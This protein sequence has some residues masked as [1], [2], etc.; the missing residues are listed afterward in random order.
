MRRILGILTAVAIAA[1][2]SASAA[3]SRPSPTCDRA[4][5]YGVL[6]QYLA[7]LRAHD[8]TRVP[9][10][11]R[12]RNTENN[13]ELTPGD[14]LWG[15]LTQLDATYEMRFAD[16]AAGQVAVYGVVDESGTRAPY[17]L[18]LKVVDRTVTEAE[19][20]I[21]RPQEAG[22]PF[23]NADIK[24]IPVWNEMLTPAQRVPRQQMIDAANGY[25]DSL[26]LNDGHVHT[27]FTDDCNRRE[28]GTQTTN[29]TGPG[30]NPIWKY[31]CEQQ[32]RL[33]AYR[34]DDRLR[35]RRFEMVDEERGIVLAGGFIDHS[36]R[37]KE[38]ALTDGTTRKSNY[39]RPHSFALFEAFKIVG[40][41]IRQVEAVFFSV[42]YNMPSPWDRARLNSSG[43]SP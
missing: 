14:G 4:C 9:W 34:Y 37:I 42:P 1:C 18:R 13:V 26:Q 5:L 40:G 22:V 24:S 23:V 11:A 29:N 28:D 2:G 41:K 12:P 10:A 32:F 36:G 38:F 33:G 35:G 43:P 27:A 20:L 16:V 7:A 6:D 39:L 30:A 31:G 8:S 21:A 25:F 15:T 19:T 17:A 3:E